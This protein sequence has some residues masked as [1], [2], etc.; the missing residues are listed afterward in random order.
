[1]GMTGYYDIVLGLIPLTLVG[2]SGVLTA[3]GLSTTAAVLLAG[4]VAAG[5]VAHAM[6]VNGP[7][8]V[9]SDPEGPFRPTN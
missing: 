1:M 9:D 2:L 7:A 5:V 3:V 4:V 8:P 6:F